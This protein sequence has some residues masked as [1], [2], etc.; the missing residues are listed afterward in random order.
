MERYDGEMGFCFCSFN[1]S[2]IRFHYTTDNFLLIQ[3]LQ[4]PQK[5]NNFPSLFTQP[6][7]HLPKHCIDDRAHE[8]YRNRPWPLSNAGNVPALPDG[9]LLHF[10]LLRP[11]FRWPVLFFRRVLLALMV[12]VVSLVVGIARVVVVVLP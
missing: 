8:I 5:T 3:P 4:V 7:K 2:S 10:S 11:S 1:H 9:E 6:T 12:V